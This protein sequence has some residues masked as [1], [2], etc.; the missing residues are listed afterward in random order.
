MKKILLATTVLVGTAGFAA[1]EVSLSGDARMGIIKTENKDAVFSNRA[2]VKFSL[3]GE[4]D[5]GLSFGASFRAHEA[6][7][8]RNIEKNTESGGAVLGDR[9]TVFISGAFG[10]LSMGDE[11]SAAEYAVGDLAGVGYTGAG[12]NNETAFLLGAKV[13]Y[14]YTAGDLSVYGSVGQPADDEFSVGVK[15]SAGGFTVGLGYEDADTDTHTVA[16]AAYTMGDTTFKVVYGTADVA[17]DTQMGASV[18]H[19]MGALSLSAFYRTVEDIDGEKANFYGV[20]A[21]YDLGG[22]AAVK[23]GLADNNKVSTAEVGVTFAF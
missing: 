15:Y 23:A 22:G 5:G 19:T 12:S 1:A 4:T 16:S 11:S 14:T 20:G 17:L 13:V 6:G 9:G 10:T 21:A 7:Y 18:A 2:R 3:S 8:T